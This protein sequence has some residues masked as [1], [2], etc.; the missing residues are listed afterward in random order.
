MQA[1]KMDF[2]PLPHSGT[3]IASAILLLAALLS[4]CAQS[5]PTP[6]PDLKRPEADGMLAPAQQKK[7]IEDLALKKAEAE[8]QAVKQIE[9][10]R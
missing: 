7:A 8:A 9:Q 3:S 5:I 4:G 2:P 6:L 10:T 1:H